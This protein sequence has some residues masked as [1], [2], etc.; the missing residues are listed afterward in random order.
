MYCKTIFNG[1][2]PIVVISKNENQKSTFEEN[3]DLFKNQN[4]TQGSAYN[5]ETMMERYSSGEMLT[6]GMFHIAGE[7][8]GTTIHEFKSGRLRVYCSKTPH[9]GLIILSNVEMKKT[10]KTPKQSLTQAKA[11][12]DAY[13]DME[14]IKLEN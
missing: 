4:T 6:D 11:A 9:G 13:M 2:K 7:Y 1:I 3:F 8:K 12:F 14:A 10:Q 5:L